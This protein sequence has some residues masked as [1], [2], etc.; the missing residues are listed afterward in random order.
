[1]FKLKINSNLSTVFFRKKF[2]LAVFFI[3]NIESQI[4]SQEEKLNQQTFEELVQVYLNPA[5]DKS[6]R[7]DIF[8]YIKKYN[9][10][11]VAKSALISALKDEKQRYYALF[12][13]SKLKISAVCKAAQP[14]IETDDGH[15]VINLIFETQDD[16]SLKFLFS[17]WKDSDPASL[18]FKQ[19]SQGFT[20]YKILLEKTDLF[21]K[22]LKSTES[23]EEHKKVA[24]KII[25]FQL[26]TNIDDEFLV[27][28]F[29][30]YKKNY[31]LFSKTILLKGDDL[32][33]DK[34]VIELTNGEEVNKNYYLRKNG[35]L[36]ITP[37]PEYIQKGNFELKV[38]VFVVIKGDE[39]YCKLARNEDDRGW[40]P[41]I[42]GNEWVMKTDKGVELA[43]APVKIGQWTTIVFKI[44]DESTEQRRFERKC[45]I[46]V[47]DNLLLPEGNASGKFSKI[48]IRAKNSEIV[49]GGIEVIK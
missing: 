16:N 48:I 23:S 6:L 4:Y 38:R 7:Y 3:L 30:T 42:Q 33:K 34:K 28:Y 41:F 24:A 14:Y 47:D 1:M 17:K 29:E 11:T 21:C 36:I 39:A 31:K 35:D 37:L 2:F 18:N 13:A 43:S 12:L 19:I 40:K 32:L 22:V 8:E 27:D 9:K 25:R 5:T 44:S 46:S 45:R 15:L 10:P 49:V 26:S 20:T